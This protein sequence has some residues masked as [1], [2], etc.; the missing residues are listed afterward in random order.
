MAA[1]KRH[2]TDAV[3]LD[4]A[5]GRFTLTVD[6]LQSIEWKADSLADDLVAE[7]VAEGHIRLHRRATIGPKIE[8]DLARA[9]AEA[10]PAKA[11][12]LRQVV[13]DRY[14]DVKFYRADN[15]RASLRQEVVMALIGDRAEQKVR[16]FLQ[17][18]DGWLDVMTNVVHL[19]RL[20]RFTDDN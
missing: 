15:D 3:W 18:A 10:D 9:A 17:V 4:V 7:V 16:L 2:R 5:K 8:S 1:A 11:G 19:E 12:E 20:R 13:A 6:I 14:H